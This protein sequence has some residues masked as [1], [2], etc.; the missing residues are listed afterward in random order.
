MNIRRLA[1]LVSRRVVL[2]RRL[3]ERFGRL[4]IYVS[5]E[6]ALRYWYSMDQVDPVLYSI[7]EE[8]V[9]PGSI[10]WDV[11]AN[12]G[13]F[14]FCA[15]ARAGQSGL[16]LAMEP[17]F[18]LAD[19]I[20]RSSQK[21]DRARYECADVRVLCASLS[22]SS[23]ISELE[24]AERARASNHLVEAVGSTQAKASRHS[25]LT[26]SL[27][28]DYL[29]DYFPAPTVL[30]IDV[31][32]HETKVLRGAA[33]LLKEARPTIWCEVAHENSAEVTQLLTEAGYE[34]YGGETHPHQ[35]TNRAWFHTLAIPVS[36]NS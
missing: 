27:T 14:S 17:D 4:P 12:V 36:F 1:E 11:G 6:A 16:V 35:R 28:L 32:T 34:L 8:L 25:Q 21:L 22:S 20:M 7:V 26:V 23:R 24:V 10:V 18:W 9:K 2:R 3:P 31:E 29:L 30:K 13:L 15:A 19:L 5:P 33:K